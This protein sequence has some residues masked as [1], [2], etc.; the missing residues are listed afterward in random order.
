MFGGIDIGSRSTELVLQQDGVVVHRAQLPTTFSPLEQCKKLLE[1]HSPEYLVATG[2]GRELVKTLE[3]SYPVDTITE[4]KAHA[5]GA[6]ALFP[7]ART[8]LDIGGQDTKAISLHSNGGILRFEMNDRCAAGTGKFLEYTANVFQLSIE[9]FGNYALCGDNPP[10]I[11]SMC[12]VFAETEATSLMAQ[13]AQPE[14]IA[15]ALHTSVVRRTS[16]MLKR[17]GLEFPLVFSGGV[18]N[19]ACIRRLLQEEFGE[20]NTIFVADEPDMCGAFG[21]SLWAEKRCAG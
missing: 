13:G 18:A 2:Y 12:T 16:T 15:L 20:Q 14:D 3:L 9:D 7:E 8:V 5:L 11:N 4:I 21:A 17:V 19:N 6:H 1:G 10:L